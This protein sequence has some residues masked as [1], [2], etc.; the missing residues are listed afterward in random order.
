MTGD[1]TGHW[2]YWE[3]SR[4]AAGQLGLLHAKQA[5]FSF[6]LSVSPL[7]MY[8]MMHPVHSGWLAPVQS[9]RAAHWSGSS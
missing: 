8:F 4:W 3:F 7:P 5:V 9:G 6:L 1:R 2:E